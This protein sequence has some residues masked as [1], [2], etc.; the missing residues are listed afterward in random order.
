MSSNKRFLDNARTYLFMLAAVIASSFASAQ[1]NQLPTPLVPPE[2]W[3][4]VEI[5]LFTQPDNLSGEI[6]PLDHH[7]EY[8]K[9]L[10]ALID[11]EARSHQFT[12]SQ[13]QAALLLDPEA[14]PVLPTTLTWI[15]IEEMEDPAITLNS[16]NQEPITLT[17]EIA[18]ETETQIVEDSLPDEPYIPEYEESFIILDARVRDL[19]DS[20]RALNR[21]NY[22][23]VFHEAWRFEADAGGEDPWIHI[24]AGKRLD[25]RSEIEGSLRFYKSRFLH[26]ETDLWRLKF[27]NQ[28]SLVDTLTV[29]LPDIPNFQLAIEDSPEQQW[30]IPVLPEYLTDLNAESELVNIGSVDHALEALVLDEVEDQQNLSDINQYPI[31]EIWPIKQSKRI[32]ESSVYY[33]DHPELGIM[34]TIKAYEPE[35]LNP[36][37]INEDEG[38]IESEIQD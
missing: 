31:A 4:Q 3:Y 22:N 10:L 8:P 12:L 9:N 18:I 32:E 37:A 1:E 35:P 33:L 23:V 29:K 34:L 26:V 5:I 25:D 38:A 17:G 19:N 20:A 6:A 24:S 27:V 15:P 28:D 16:S 13:I 7:L 2:N 14:T 11:A 21:R 30:Q 36:Q